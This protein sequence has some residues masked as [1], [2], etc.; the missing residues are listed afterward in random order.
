[1]SLAALILTF[2]SISGERETGTLRLIIANSVPRSHILVS[3]LIG[4]YVVLLIPFISSILVALLVLAASPDISLTSPLVWPAV[5]VILGV[6]LLFL[7]GMVSLGVSISAFTKHSMN[8]MVLAFFLWAILVL[9]IPKVSPMVAGILYPIEAESTVRLAEQTSVDDIQAE[10]DQVRQKFLVKCFEEQSAPADDMNRSPPRTEEGKKARARYEEEIISIART[11]QKRIAEK[12]RQ[13]EQDYTHRRNVQ[14]AIAMNLSRIS[15]VSGYAYVVSAI[16]GTG[17][18]EPDNFII[19]ARR[20]QD[21][22]EEAV[23]GKYFVRVGSMDV[24]NGPEG[25]NIHHLPPV[26]DMAYAYPELTITLREIWPDILLL[27]LFNLLF[28]ALAF[29]RLNKYDAR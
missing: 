12:V 26:P 4:S 22:V 5:L 17:V 11:Y 18:S 3:K 24:G 7:L 27:G 9:G 20:Y 28:C 15:P 23:Y 2:N 19:N 6:T 16:T 10:F 13:I 1:M 25:F 14:S 21:Q 29:T 8:S